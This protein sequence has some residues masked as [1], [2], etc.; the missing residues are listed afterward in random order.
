MV[1]RLR[2]RCSVL[3]ELF[4]CEAGSKQSLSQ[5]HRCYHDACR[6]K[7]LK[8][9]FEQCLFHECGEQVYLRKMANNNTWS[10]VTSGPLTMGAR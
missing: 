9:D 6:G 1:R 5:D 2:T 4:T 7:R 10:L 3:T 8:T